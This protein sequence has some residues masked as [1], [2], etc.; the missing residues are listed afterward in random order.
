MWMG[1]IY[2][3]VCDV[4]INIAVVLWLFSDSEFVLSQYRTSARQSFSVDMFV[5]GSGK[6]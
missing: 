5:A 3:R 6:L 2:G 1:C 4:F